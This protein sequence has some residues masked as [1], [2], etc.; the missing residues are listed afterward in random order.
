M[1]QKVYPRRKDLIYPDLCYKIIGI[2]YEVHNELGYGYKEKY[3]QKAIAADL[4][5][6]GIIF[7]EQVAALVKFKR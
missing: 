6:R 7:K 2:L 5:K 3:Y 4:N 1:Q